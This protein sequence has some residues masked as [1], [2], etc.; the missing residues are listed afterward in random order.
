[1]D[2]HPGNAEGDWYVDTRC[3]DCST[4]RTLAPEVFGLARRQSVVVRQPGDD[5]ATIDAWRAA[6]A[7]PTQ[8]IGTRSRQRRPEGL[9]PQLLDDGVYFCGFASEHS[10]GASAYLVVRPEGNLLVDSPRWSRLLAA[11]IAD[12]GGIGDVLLTHCDDV[13]DAE[14]WAA[15]FGARVWIH[16]RDAHAAPFA[17]NVVTG[18]SAVEIRPG[19]TIVPL[20]G[21]TE[22]SVAYL[23]EERYLFSG[24]SLA[25]EGDPGDLTAFRS[26]C[27]YSWAEQ[28]TSLAALAEHHRFSWV[29][30]GHGGRHQGDP[31]DLHRRLVDLARRM[32]IRRGA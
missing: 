22:G 10:Y 26:V 24:D 19:L 4:C 8:S 27:W 9:F 30:P 1:M 25:W 20:P 18:R 21:H 2:R 17:T 32:P 31:E 12:L 23:L 3:I 15:R 5:A 29:L 28:T 6:L 13:A 7:C 11:P 14:K 16:A